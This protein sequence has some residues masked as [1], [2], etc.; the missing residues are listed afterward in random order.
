MSGASVGWMGALGDR[1]QDMRF[2]VFCVSMI[3]ETHLAVL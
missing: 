1:R 3:R 2:E